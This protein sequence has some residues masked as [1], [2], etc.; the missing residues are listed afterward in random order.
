MLRLGIKRSNI[1]KEDDLR[2]KY[3]DTKQGILD[4]RYSA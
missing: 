4:K 3:T 1:G 2:I